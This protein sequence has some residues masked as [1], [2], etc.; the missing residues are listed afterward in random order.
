MT[1]KYT[2]IQIAHTML[3]EICGKYLITS[4]GIDQQYNDKEE[5]C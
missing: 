1:G 4:D 3:K 2:I 5:K